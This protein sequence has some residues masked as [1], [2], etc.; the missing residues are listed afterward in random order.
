MVILKI[1]LVLVVGG[2]A[3]LAFNPIKKG[4]V[5]D[6]MGNV[7]SNNAVVG[8]KPG[9]IGV[10]L[11]AVILAMVLSSGF[12]TVPTGYKGVVERWNAAT[13]KQL[14]SG[15]YWIMPVRDSVKMM[16]VQVT[17]YENDVSAASKDQQDIYTSLV[18]N[19]RVEAEN[20]A[21]L[22]IGYIGDWKKKVLDPR[23]EAVV[24][25]NTAMYKADEILQNR[26]IMA[27]QIL[28]DLQVSAADAFI[29][30]TS[31]SITNIDFTV[32]YKASIEAKVIAGQRA[33]EAENMLRQV[34][35]EAAQTIEKA[36][37]E[38]EKIRIQAEAIQESGG[39]EYVAL[40]MVQRWNGEFPDT[41]VGGGDGGGPFQLLDISNMLGN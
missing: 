16:N 32:E 41:Y 27:E 31:V 9:K 20:A 1:L 39:R 3:Y 33:L 7:V 36:R 29:E 14:D 37:A 12:G 21:N 18:V 26:A 10:I 8:V 30:I 40:Q 15:I 19:Y 11:G 17:A 38:A 24:K 25:A 34:E 6:R 35:F 22:H 13:G 2:L 23:I 4:T 28:E 5:K